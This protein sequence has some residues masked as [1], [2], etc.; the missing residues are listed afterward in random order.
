[1]LR[2]GLPLVKKEASTSRKLPVR[3]SSLGNAFEVNGDL[4][5]GLRV[6]LV[7]WLKRQPRVLWDHSVYLVYC[8]GTL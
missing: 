5:L 8:I 4:E 1:M 6:G 3:F 2:L 7:L